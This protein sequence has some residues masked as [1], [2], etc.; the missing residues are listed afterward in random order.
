MTPKEL[1]KTLFSIIVTAAALKAALGT[2]SRPMQGGGTPPSVR[3][4]R[5]GQV[6]VEGLEQPR[7]D[8]LEYWELL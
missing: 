1:G 7:Y 3:N 2:L 6:P 5:L 8:E 4:R